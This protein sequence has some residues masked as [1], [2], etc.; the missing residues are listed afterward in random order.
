MINYVV[1]APWSETGENMK[2]I[3]PPDENRVKL[4][5]HY[6]LFG[7]MYLHFTEIAF[8]SVLWLRN[9]NKEKKNKSIYIY[10][11]LLLLFCLFAALDEAYFNI[12][13]H[14][15]DAHINFGRIDCLQSKKVSQRHD[16][17]FSN[18]RVKPE[19]E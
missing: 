14:A 17:Q 10:I 18:M 11:S 2:T 13:E 19:E 3:E 6:S 1:H 16:W 8:I 7:G 12:I 9:L 4:A 5:I 15:Y